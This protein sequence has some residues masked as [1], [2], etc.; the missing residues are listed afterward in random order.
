MNLYSKAPHGWHGQWV[1]YSH[2][3][4]VSESSMDTAD[5]YICDLIAKQETLRSELMRFYSPPS[6]LW[7]GHCPQ[8][9]SQRMVIKMWLQGL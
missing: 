5:W 2:F 4:K 7:Q 8:E 6:L 9:R 1:N 3:S